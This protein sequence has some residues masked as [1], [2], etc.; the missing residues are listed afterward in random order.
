MSIAHNSET[1]EIFALKSETGSNSQNHHH[2]SASLEILPNMLSKKNP[3]KAKQDKIC[4]CVWYDYI[5]T[6]KKNY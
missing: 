5:E 6:P 2:Y 3:K 4:Y 1:L